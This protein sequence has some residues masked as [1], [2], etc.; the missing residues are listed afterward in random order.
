MAPSSDAGQAPA[1]DT[2]ALPEQP[3]LPKGIAVTTLA[4]P[5][6]AV[7]PSG[8]PAA[9]VAPARH[10]LYALIH[11]ALRA[12]MFDALQR[13]GRMDCRDPADLAGATETAAALLRQ[14][15]SHLGHEND[16]VHAAIEARQPQGAAVTAGDHVEHLASIGALEDELSALRAAPAEQRAAVAQRLYRHLALF[17]AENL[18]HMHIEET[19]NNATLW[20]LYSEEELLALHDRLVASID[21]AEMA[22]IARWMACAGDAEELAGLFAGMKAKAPPA[23]FDSLIGLAREAMD[24]GR[25]AKLARAVG[26][27]PVPGLVTV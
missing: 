11:K 10:D 6:A 2:G 23:V 4:F 24:E 25:W 5:S 16:F 13:L 20:A 3:A 22:G 18:Q 21:P 12:Q 17:V 26:V 9:P 27:P 1:A 8:R 15:R 7:S 19:A 14:L